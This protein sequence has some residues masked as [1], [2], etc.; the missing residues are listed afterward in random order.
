MIYEVQERGA[1]EVVAVQD[2]AGNTKV[3]ITAFEESV[4]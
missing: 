3:A 4:P 1:L 2:D